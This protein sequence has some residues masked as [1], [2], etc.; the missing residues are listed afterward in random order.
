MDIERLSLLEQ[1]IEPYRQAGF[2]VTSQT[3]GSI[4]LALPPE[5]FSYLI[6]IVTLILVWPVAVLYLVSFN[7]QRGRSVCLR[8]TSQGYVEASGYT[9]GV[10]DRERKRRRLVAIIA[11]CVCALIILLIVIGVYLARAR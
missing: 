11:L 4:T 5:K 6:F 7:N 10:I 8:V 3:E 2:V 1:A 9:L